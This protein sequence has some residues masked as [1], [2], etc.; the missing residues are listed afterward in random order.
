MDSTW[1]VNKLYSFLLADVAFELNYVIQTSLNK[2][3]LV[4]YK[5]LFSLLQLFKAVAHK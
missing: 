4:L 1:L 2:I 3:R 5:L